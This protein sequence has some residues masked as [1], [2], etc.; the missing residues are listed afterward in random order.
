M[1]F[2]LLRTLALFFG[3]PRLIPVFMCEILLSFISV[4]ARYPS[5]RGSILH[6][7]VLIPTSVFD[8]DFPGVALQ[9]ITIG[10]LLLIPSISSEILTVTYL[11]L[12]ISFLLQCQYITQSYNNNINCVSILEWVLSFIYYLIN[13]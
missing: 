3:L 8:S 6:S 2:Y 4:L 9:L 12:Y 13:L 10:L 5:N 11:I 1:S 7:G